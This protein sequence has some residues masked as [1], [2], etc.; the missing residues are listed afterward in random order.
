M[1]KNTELAIMWITTSVTIMISLFITKNLNC[2]WG[3]SIP[4]ILELFSIL[5]TVNN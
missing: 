2:L 5:F 1:S 3:F 4:G